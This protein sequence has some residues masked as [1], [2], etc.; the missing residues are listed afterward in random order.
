MDPKNS[1]TLVDKAKERCVLLS[2]SISSK[3][4][5]H[6]FYLY[7]AVIGVQLTSTS[8]VPNTLSCICCMQD[9]GIRFC[10]INTNIPP[11]VIPLMA[12]GKIMTYLMECRQF[13]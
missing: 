4:C 1:S 6:N 10:L 9:F 13:V 11:S 7:H 2:Y 8:V 3:E 5:M 12:M